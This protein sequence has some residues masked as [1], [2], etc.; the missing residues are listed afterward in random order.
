MTR[1]NLSDLIKLRL[2]VLGA[3]TRIDERT[4]WWL[5]DMVRRKLL[6]QY[7]DKFG[8]SSRGH[9]TKTVIGDIKFD[10][11][12]GLKYTEIDFIDTPDG[13]EIV[14]VSKTQEIHN[15]FIQ[16]EVGQSAV[17]SGLEASDIMTT[18]WHEA[19]R[20]YFNGLGFEVTQV[21]VRCSPSISSLTDDEDIPIPTAIEDDMIEGVAAKIMNQQPVDKVPDTR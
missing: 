21:A 2:G 14:S 17:Y 6:A 13:S 8:S 7:V 10:S 19:D 11:T 12:T 16:Q 1:K 20:I 3:D 5:A 15:P 18:W 4:I 9:W